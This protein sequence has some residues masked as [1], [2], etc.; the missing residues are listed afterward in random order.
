MGTRQ[1]GTGQWLINNTKFRQWVEA[2]KQILFCPGI[3]GA[4]K[5]I[6][7][8]ILIDY[9][10]SRFANDS[11]V[12]IAYIYLN[13]WQQEEH[14]M[15][16]LFANLLKQLVSRLSPLPLNVRILYHEHKRKGSRPSF[17]KI[18]SV[19]QSIMR[20]SYKRVFIVADALDECR[21]S[22]NCQ[23][24][25]IEGLFFLQQCGASVLA[26]SRHITEIMN[27]F[28]KSTWLEIRASQDDIRTYIDSQISQ[29]Q[30]KTLLEMQTEASIGIA[31]AAD[32][33][34]V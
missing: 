11:E 16:G 34:Y 13:F 24:R 25:F 32:G 2:D 9:L 26:T 23:M 30:S 21:E 10:L 1:E 33:M 6:L 5:S 7:A 18:L 17:E 28:D 3:P 14:T 12:G 20:F 8:A 31:V 15:Q 22:N 19:L 4:G 27:R 29:R